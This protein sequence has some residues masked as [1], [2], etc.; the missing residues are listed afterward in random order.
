MLYRPQKSSGGEVTWVGG[1]LQLH[2]FRC[3][4]FS[5]HILSRKLNVSSEFPGVRRYERMVGFLCR[6]PPLEQADD[7]ADVAGK[8]TLFGLASWYIIP[9][10]FIVRV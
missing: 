10:L 8:Q 5:D 2:E 1:R 3:C 9:R 4:G 7:S 6:E